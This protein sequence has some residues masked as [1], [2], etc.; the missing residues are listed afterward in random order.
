MTATPVSTSPG[1]I[2]LP[3]V[4]EPP[5]RHPFPLLASV[6]P[7][8]GSLVIWAITSS[9]FALVFAFLGPVI[10]VGTMLDGRIT[11]RRSLA[12]DR[13][14]FQRDLISTR[15]AIQEA[16]TV[17]AKELDRIHPGALSIL[18]AA[19]R[20]PERWRGGFDQPLEI[21]LGWGIQPSIL[22]VDGSATTS[23]LTALTQEAASIQAPIIADARLGIGIVGGSIAGWALARGL[24]LQLANLLPPETGAWQAAGSE[25]E[26][27]GLLPHAHASA[28]QDARG[29][30]RWSDASGSALISVAERSADLPHSVRVVISVGGGEGARLLAHPGLRVPLEMTTE[31]ISFV[32]ATAI[33]RHLAGC[34][35]GRSGSSKALPL[36][37]P[38]SAVAD[39]GSP[40]LSVASAVAR[41]RGVL[42]A[43][44]LVGPEGVV[45]L[46]LATDG[47]HAVIG[48]TTG[49]GK[50]ELLLSWLVAIALRSA[51]DEVNFLLVD[52]KGGASF[53]PIID[54]PHVV[55]LVTDLD[56]R[57]AHRALSS[58]R[59][60]VRFR[61]RRLAA[62]AVRSIEELEGTDRLPR[63]VIVVDEFAAL[64]GGFP[65]LHEL[66]ADLAARGRSLG[67]HLVL[68]TQRPAGVV[69]DS[70][71]A[72][73][74]L[75][76]SL[77]VNNR[78]DSTAVIGTD[79]AAA[80]PA[81]PRGRAMVA[82]AGADPVMVQVALTDRAD[83][84]RAME[85]WEG[86]PLPR[87]PWCD[88]L[89]LV[90]DPAVLNTTAA[91]FMIGLADLPDEQRQ[92]TAD[93][94][95]ATDGNLLVL[96]GAAS[97][98]S[99]F[100]AL[101]E[102]QGA[103]RVPGDI[104]GAWDALA[105]AVE[106]V[107]RGIA[108]PRVLLIDDVDALIGRF[109][110][111][112][113]SAFIDLLLEL[114]RTGA[115]AGISVV[116]TA[117]RLPARVQ[118]LAASCDC[119]MLLCHPNRQ[120]YLLSGGDTSLF[121]ADSPAGRAEW[122]GV[123]VQ[124]ASA[125]PSADHASRPVALFQPTKSTLVVSNRPT[126]FSARYP[127]CHVIELRP[128]FVPGQADPGQ[129][130]V[131]P[132]SRPTILVGDADSWQANWSHLIALRSTS[133]MIFDQCSVADFRIF[134]ASR[135][136]PPPLAPHSGSVWKLEPAH[137]PTRVRLA[138]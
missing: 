82:F 106:S 97:G 59:A 137:P 138:K 47:P 43:R 91:G 104:E 123:M 136:L 38:L 74:P 67:V 64:V 73:V 95:P 129:I 10:A 25:R 113:D 135:Q 100:L 108:L 85:R 30:L 18:T 120:D 126:E 29:D 78:A 94:N 27:L 46:D 15:A 83:V 125:D 117:R 35:A 55:G 49:S 52:F 88:D 37:I 23:E 107:R 101:L 8:I 16:H 17:E 28:G 40:E 57:S 41:A 2:A 39:H 63:L 33:A 114:L 72:N 121:S 134:S 89:P 24:A 109:G 11:G 21:T 124:L 50:S 69:R 54:L 1:P 92:A 75:R 4:P 81:H 96:G 56:E 110:D 90:I 130:D 98:K 84:A 36:S 3:R 14:A 58:L 71:L 112:H 79:A 19:S 61:E 6:A 68:C 48:G 32:Q 93:W 103:E 119:R 12:R 76:L 70:V 111:D 62:A 132:A 122:R 42:D 22:R 34:A 127:E 5:S 86:R 87:R 115:V 53:G 45:S 99:S 66:F 9:P 131:G 118:A 80:L 51:P 13:V 77:R 60:E 128:T 116:V 44:F 26:W 102:N 31:S 20:D 7:V 105:A 133:T 65:E